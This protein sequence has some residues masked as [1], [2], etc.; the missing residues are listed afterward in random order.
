MDH[1]IAEQHRR[2]DALFD[3]ARA[4]LRR[5]DAPAARRALDD[6]RLALDAH[7]EQEDR[8]YYPPIGAL[9]PEHRGAVTR[10]GEAHA[11]FR[12]HLETIVRALDSPPLE[13][14]ERAFED[15]AEAFARHEQREEELLRSL[16]SEAAGL[17]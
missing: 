5:G 8:L 13:R 3:G 7:F 1:P 14:A 9:R 17:R 16:E 15:F 2:L 10:F 6:L 11:R 4:T 12:A